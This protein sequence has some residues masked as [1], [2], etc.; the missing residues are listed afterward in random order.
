MGWALAG[1]TIEMYITPLVNKCLEIVENGEEADYPNGV[2]SMSLLEQHP[3]LASIPNYLVGPNNDQLPGPWRLQ[4]FCAND[5]ETDAF[6][7]VLNA[8]WD[9]VGADD[10]HF[11]D[12]GNLGKKL[13]VVGTRFWGAFGD[14]LHPSWNVAVQHLRRIPN[15]VRRRPQHVM[16]GTLVNICIRHGGIITLDNIENQIFPPIEQRMLDYFALD[17]E[18]PQYQAPVRSFLQIRTA[19][20]SSIVW[21]REHELRRNLRK[22][23]RFVFYNGENHDITTLTRTQCALLE[24][25][26]DPPF[27]MAVNEGWL[28]AATQ[29]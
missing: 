15:N 11:L 24:R 9:V 22:S 3:D 12:E 2:D 23:R 7:D 26:P 16:R 20:T 18:D 21:A 25:N 8:L 29:P 28:W 27:T 6:V 10:P 14:N 4:R 1:D 19:P 5:S 17:T 13:G